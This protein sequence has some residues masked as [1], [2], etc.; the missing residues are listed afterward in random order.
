MSSA[1]LKN[2]WKIKGIVDE[3]DTFEHSCIELSDDEQKPSLS[4]PNDTSEIEDDGSDEDESCDSD[5]SE[6]CGAIASNK[7]AA[8]DMSD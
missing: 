2:I 7:F 5:S 3:L 6:V 1:E 8:L 4:G